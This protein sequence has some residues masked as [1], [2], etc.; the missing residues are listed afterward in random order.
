MSRH[1]QDSNA[2]VEGFYQLCSSERDNIPFV[3]EPRYDMKS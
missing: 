3:S 2:I 1:R